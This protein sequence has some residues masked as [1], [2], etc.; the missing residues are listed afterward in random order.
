MIQP[1]VLAPKETLV[2]QAKRHF[3]ETFAKREKPIY[4]YHPR[5]VKQVATWARRLLNRFP[6]ANPEVLMVSVWLHDIG[7]S[8]G[9]DA[10]DHA[11]RSEAE[12][13]SFLTSAGATPE[14]VA[15]A[16]HCVRTHRNKDVPPE[17]LEAKILAAADSASHLTDFNYIVHCTDGM[18]EYALSKLERDIRD[19]NLLPGLQEELSPLYVAWKQLLEAFPEDL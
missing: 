6:E 12:A 5:H 3:L 17:T 10:I 1:E 16:C 19:V 2:E 18:K 9:D 11:V 14:L 7:W 8:I 4:P 13:Y 15:R